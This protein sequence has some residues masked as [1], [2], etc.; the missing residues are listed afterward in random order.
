MEVEIGAGSAFYIK[1]WCFH[2]RYAVKKIRVVIGS[3]VYN[4]HTI[5]LF[6]P[7]VYHHFRLQGLILDH[8]VSCG[9]WSLIPLKYQKDEILPFKIEITLKNHAVYEKDL[10][11]LRILGRIKESEELKRNRQEIEQRTEEIRSKSA[12]RL[13]AICLAIYNPDEVMFERQILSITTQSYPNWIWLI[14][15]DC[16]QNK[17]YHFI[18]KTVADDPGFMVFR[19]N[20]NIGFYRNF[21]NS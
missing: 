10:G 8:S 9:F 7:D 15:D 1:G 12:G 11:H 19:N 17:K 21:E 3:S 5:N 14:N 18:Q 2:S 20:E 4:L 6:R 13:V 16:S